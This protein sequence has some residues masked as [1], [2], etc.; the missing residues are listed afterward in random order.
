[1]A[2]IGRGGQAARSGRDG[3]PVLRRGRADDDLGRFVRLDCFVR[4]TPPEALSRW[5]ASR[6]A[7]SQPGTPDRCDETACSLAR[8][9][10]PS[11]GT[12][13][14][15]FYAQAVCPCYQAAGLGEGSGAAG[16]TDGF[17]TTDSVF[18]FRR[19]GFRTEV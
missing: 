7:L 1:M 3:E 8:S 11:A 12:K 16:P 18:G 17:Y 10:A 2:V 9:V 14:S 5:L 15:A 6:T 19:G 13:S 4:P